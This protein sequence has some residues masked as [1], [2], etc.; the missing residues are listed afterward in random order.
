MDDERARSLNDDGSLTQDT[1]T[2]KVQAMPHGDY[3]NVTIIPITVLPA[4]VDFVG[5]ADSERRHHDRHEA[6]TGNLQASYDAASRTVTIKNQDG[7]LLTK[8]QSIDTYIRVKVTSFTPDTGIT[9]GLRQPGDDRA[10][11]RLPAERPEEGCEEPDQ[12]H[13]RP[14]RDVRGA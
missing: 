11:Q 14:E 7:T 2:Y 6:L 10:D 3:A 13:H 4:G 12:G 8:Q 1:F 9:N 5:F